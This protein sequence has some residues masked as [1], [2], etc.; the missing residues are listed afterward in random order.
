MISGLTS[1]CPLL[2]SSTTRIGSR[3][4]TPGPVVDSSCTDSRR[5]STRSTRG[6]PPLQPASD[7]TSAVSASREGEHDT[8]GAR[9]ARRSDVERGMA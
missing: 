3:Y 1:G 2:D 4:W 5:G 8:R 7:A 6:A 9:T